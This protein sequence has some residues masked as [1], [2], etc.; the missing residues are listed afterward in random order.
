MDK[1]R[2]ILSK[3]EID[4]IKKALE[5]ECDIL[6]DTIKDI[7]SE[8]K[9]TKDME[10][11]MQELKKLIEKI[12]RKTN[13]LDYEELYYKT[14]REQMLDDRVDML[15]DMMQELKKENERLKK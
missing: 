7:E 1:I 4:M 12:D 10:N 6:R 8:G 5:I 13:N 15:L 14:E 2:L 3:V 11:E 9:K